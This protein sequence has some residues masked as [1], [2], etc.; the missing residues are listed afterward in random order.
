MIPSGHTSVMSSRREPPDSLDF[1]PT[2][3]WSTRALIAHVL[4]PGGDDLAVSTAWDPCCGEGHMVGP[5]REN[6]LAAEGTDVFDY[7]KGFAVADFL[8]DEARSADWLIFNPPFKIAEAFALR[9]LARAHVGVAMLVRSVWLEGTGRYDRLFKARPP[10]IVALFCERV[11]MTKGRWDPNASTATSYAW[12]VWYVTPRASLP[13]FAWIPPGCRKGL[14]RPDD[15]ARY[16][17]QVDSP[18]LMAAE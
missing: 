3:P 4:L 13:T 10:A 1:F 9:A 11:P 8:A 6:F 2:P 12:V 16:G 5:L 18:L 14:T 17:V 7:G 15:A